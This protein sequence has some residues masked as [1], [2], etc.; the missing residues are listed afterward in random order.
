MESRAA[1]TIKKRQIELK[2]RVTPAC[3]NV[4]HGAMEILMRKV[5]VDAR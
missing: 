1:R 5:L 4:T 3:R 2:I